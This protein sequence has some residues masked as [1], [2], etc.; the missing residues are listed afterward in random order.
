M[1]KDACAIASKFTF[2]VILS[3]RAVSGKC[4][5]SI[6]AYVIV[7]SD[8]WVVTAG[9]V[10][11]EMFSAV[12]SVGNCRTR[13][14]R[15]AAIRS[16]P[17][18]SDRDRRSQL[19]SIGRPKPEDIDQCSVLWGGLPPNTQMT[20]GIIIEGVDLGIAKLDPFD[21]SAPRTYPVFKDPKVDFVPG[22][23]LC[24]TGYP[25]HTFTPTYDSASNTFSLPAGALPI[26]P[27][28]IEGLFSR[29]INVTV[30]NAVLPSFPLLWVETSSPGL[31]GQS[32]KNMVGQLYA[33]RFGVL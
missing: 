15:E 7:N 31:R 30:P 22:V 33:L 20:N 26:P 2:P 18:L 8:G 27:F 12:A 5:S 4:A 25:F 16:D 17:K 1:F 6:G 29:I 13:A 10:L 24:K 23:M 19:R 14:T 28:P 21:G 11:K 3:T 32:G 9:H